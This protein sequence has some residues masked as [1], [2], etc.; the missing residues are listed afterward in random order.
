MSAYVARQPIFN[1]NLEIYG[2]ELLFRDEAESNQ[3]T[4]VGGD[5]A[6]S[7]TIVNSFHDIGIERIT[8]GKR[9]F[10]NFT[11]KLL[12][13]KVATILPSKI[14]VIEVLETILPTKEILAVC[15]E[16]RTMGYLIALDDFILSPEYMP[17]IE[18][19][20][21][22]KVDFMSSPMDEIEA[23]AKS[24]KTR[25]IRLLAEK[26]ET[27]E[28]FEAAKRMG[29]RLFQGYFFSKPVIMK[30][31]GVLGPLKVN[32]MRLIHLSI[33]PDVNFSK[34]ADIIKQDTALSFL[35]LR[36]V[37]SAFFGMRYKI[38]GI[39]QALAILGMTELKKWIT[40]ISM[41]RLKDNRP[42]ELITI[43]LIR[44]RFLELAAPLAGIKSDAENLFMIGLM[45]LMDAIMDMPLADILQETS[46]SDEISE[47]LLTRTGKRGDM[48][49]MIIAYEYSEWDTAQ[50]L[51]GKC[52]LT[53]SKVSTLYIDSIEWAHSIR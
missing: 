30:S 38:K 12:L 52:S 2:Y 14:L 43:A 3:F 36:V 28:I 49:S 13:D 24:I 4:D 15:S 48:L 29:F 40:I 23:F 25:P 42:G 45:S 41:T 8:D 9:A 26:I 35:L 19:A 50:E 16:L 10:V 46:V 33:Q 31:R 6:S 17:F 1:G 11:E 39:R 21:I 7:E 20:D 27:Y 34:I 5:A 37:N 51:A 44:A 32:C 22:I 47:T 18:V 53:M